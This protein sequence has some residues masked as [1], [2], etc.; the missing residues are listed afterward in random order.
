MNKAIY[1][2]TANNIISGYKK[3]DEYLIEKETDYIICKIITVML[4]VFSDKIIGISFDRNGINFD[5]KYLF[6]EK[7]EKSLFKWLDHLIE[8]DIPTS[9]SQFGK[10]KVDFEN[11]YYKIGGEG[12][13][14][15]YKKSYLLTP[16]E[17]SKALG[18]S[19]VT[20]NKY[21]K[22]GLECIDTNSHQKIPKY[23]TQLWNDP[24]YAVRMQMIEQKKKIRNQTP[25]DR[26]EEINSELTQLQIKHRSSSFEEA[27]SEYDG[28][29][30]DDP[31]DYYQWRDL[32]N[33]R[34]EIFR[35]LG[36]D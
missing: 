17:A 35:L 18:I 11:W 27:F 14:F 6:S 36:G 9:D 7:H 4:S 33:E 26:L 10:M 5:T 24:V 20:L 16:S 34:K 13:A 29:S 31:S 12:I 15:H 32:E 22:Q 3:H 1:E 25:A 19:K 28:D 21:I 30:M 2:V 8:M 23:V